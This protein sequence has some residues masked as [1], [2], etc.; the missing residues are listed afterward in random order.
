MTIST[1]TARADYATNG[2]TGPFTVPFYF[3]DNSHLRVIYKDASGNETTLAL[4]SGYTV[5]GAGNPS[6]G[7]VTTATAYVAGGTLTIIRDVPATQ[8]TDYTEGG[9]FPAETHEAALDK[10]TMLVQQQGEILSRALVVSEATTTSQVLPD[11]ASRADKLVS[12]DTTG[13]CIAVAPVEGTANALAVDLASTAAGKGAVLVAFIHEPAGATPRDLMDRGRDVLYATD[14]AGVD[15]TGGADSQTGMQAFFNA[16]ANRHGIIPPGTYLATFLSAPSGATI[17]GAGQG[18]TIIK[19]NANAPGNSSVIDF[20]S[21]SNFRLRN[22]TVDG[23]KA[24]QTNAANNVTVYACSNYSIEHVTSIG[25]KGAG[26]GY[27]A[28]FIFVEG[29]NIA[30][31]KRGWVAFNT[32]NSNDG[33]GIYVNKESNLH[34]ASNHCLSNGETGIS[35]QNFAFPPV[36]NVH[37]SISITDNQCDYNGGSGIDISGYTT[38]GTPSAPIY[39]PDTPASRYVSVTGNKCSFNALYGIA[40]QGA[41]GA[42]IGNSCSR[43]GGASLGGGILFNASGSACTENTC[44]DNDWYGIDAGGSFYCTVSDNVVEFTAA[45]NSTRAAADINVGAAVNCVVRGNVVRQADGRALIGINAPGIDGDGSTPFPT[46]GSGSVIDGNLVFVGSSGLGYW[47]S[48]QYDR[49]VLRNN[50]S[51]NALANKAFVMEVSGIVQ[52]GNHD[53]LSFS[54]GGPVFT[55]TAAATTVIPDAGDHFFVSGNTGITRI[56]TFSSNV[57]AGRV[58]EV[59]MSNVG[60][61][62]TSKPTVSFS[63][64]GGSGAAATAEFDNGG[65]I[66]GVQITNNGSGY[67]SA[68]TVSFS[69]GGGTGAAGAAVVGCNN[70]EGR[71]ITI[72]F[73][74]TPVVTDGGNISLAGNLSATGSTMLKLRGAYGNWYEVSRVTS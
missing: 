21:R 63:G 3:L 65:R 62:Y 40:Y 68:P 31:G 73:T 47:A 9:D 67:T 52:S 1:A 54:S 35:V 39:G 8:E 17:E 69:G 5:T 66:I 58:R 10:L 27:G 28:G 30:A 25:A 74:G 43:N 33:K 46:R 64:G 18:L 26:G 38:G 70:F 23:N 57:F 24:S 15:P 44:R 36:G 45:T 60:S 41:N 32:S 2:T 56:E 49:L 37:L 6:G 19:R 29:G 14:F 7:T 34:L 13:A 20:F 50:V 11:I 53:D 51:R 55:V 72:Q 22:L 61:G 59:I 42:V 12:F 71:E 4:S 48:R 16:C